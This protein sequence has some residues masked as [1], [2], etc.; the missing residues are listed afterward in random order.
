MG[1]RPVRPRKPVARMPVF[2]SVGALD[3]LT[4]ADATHRIDDGLP[5]TL[6]QWIAYNGITHI[7]IKLNGDDSNW[8]VDRVANIHRATTETQEKR[9]VSHWVYSLDFNERCRNVDYLLEFI[10]DLEAKARARSN[11]SSTSSSRP[12]AT[13]RQ[14]GRTL[15]SRRQ[16]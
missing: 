8:D 10:R 7:K 12:R 6:Q 3:A 11:A 15:C 4:D 13:W 1:T 9:K 2:H 16:N 14:T 5:E